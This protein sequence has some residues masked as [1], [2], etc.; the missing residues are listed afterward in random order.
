MA[1]GPWESCLDGLGNGLGYAKILV[2]VAF[3]RELLGS[4]TLLG[5]N[6]LNYD[7]IKNAGYV[8][9]YPEGIRENGGQYTH[10]AVWLAKA[11]FMLNNPNKG[12]ELLNLPVNLGLAGAFQAGLKYAYVKGYSYA[13]QFDAD[14]QHRPEFIEP[15]LER[16]KQGYDIVIGSRFVNIKKETFR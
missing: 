1:N 4:G 16:I 9:M 10:G 15:M 8:N 12:Y 5:Y 11:F 3:I 6:I 7:V 2:I 14:G 13:I